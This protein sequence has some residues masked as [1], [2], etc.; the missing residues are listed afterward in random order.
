M[1]EPIYEFGKMEMGE[2]TL[3]YERKND[4]KTV[5]QQSQ[6]SHM[7][8]GLNEIYRKK[9]YEKLEVKEHV[10][11]DI[12]G[13]VGETAVYFCN[14]G[15]SHVYVFEPAYKQRYIM[16]NALFNHMEDRITSYKAAVAHK[17]ETV[18]INNTKDSFGFTSFEELKEVSSDNETVGCDVVAF[19][20]IAKEKLEGIENAVLKIDCEGGEYD[21]L[22]NATNGDLCRYIQIAVEIHMQK[23]DVALLKKRLS[24]CFKGEKVDTMQDGDKIITETWVYTRID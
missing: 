11:I 6:D 23:V 18:L 14:R 7:I 9:V 2:D 12:G 15:A 16:L 10:V 19:A 4:I 8:F 13:Y 21:I 20:D 3:I 22:M 24:E 5:C 17:R 1:T